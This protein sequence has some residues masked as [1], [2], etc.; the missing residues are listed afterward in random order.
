MGSAWTGWILWQCWMTCCVFYEAMP[1]THTR[2]EW[3]R[4]RER[5]RKALRMNAWMHNACG[6]WFHPS[7]AHPLMHP[8][9]HPSRSLSLALLIYVARQ[10]GFSR[11]ATP[12]CAPYR[13]FFSSS[14][15][16]TCS[17]LLAP[18]DNVRT[19]IAQRLC[20]N[21][22]T[23]CT[24]PQLFDFLFRFLANYKLHEE[25]LKKYQFLYNRYLYCGCKD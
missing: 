3:T 22:Q 4:E 13:N 7:P 11:P 8:P 20:Q 23:S 18:R 1:A 10:M 21:T 15:F 14:F 25:S 2:R 24:T 5:E 19:V 12:R 6:H 9:F 17:M 16:Y